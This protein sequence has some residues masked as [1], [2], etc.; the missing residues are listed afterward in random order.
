MFPI[1]D[2]FFIAGLGSDL[3]LQPHFQ[4]KLCPIRTKREQFYVSY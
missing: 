1:A 3:Q 2:Y 4:S